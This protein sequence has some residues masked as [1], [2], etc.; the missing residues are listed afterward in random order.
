MARYPPWGHNGGPN[1]EGRRTNPDLWR[2]IIRMADKRVS[3]ASRSPATLV[4][5][6][7]SLKK[8]LDVGWSVH[9]I[10]QTA[11]VH[12]HILKW[13][14]SGP[15]DIPHQCPATSCLARPTLQTGGFSPGGPDQNNP[16]DRAN[17]AEVGGFR[18]QERDKASPRHTAGQMVGT[19]AARGCHCELARIGFRVGNQLWKAVCRAPFHRRCPHVRIP[20][21][22]LPSPT[23]ADEYSENVPISMQV[24]A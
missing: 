6:L 21:R 13:A 18:C 7:P 4:L 9:S 15:C 1:G 24:V 16:P 11:S 17:W 5:A 22:P 10:L 19:S 14:A 23:L 3:A 12:A 20:V 2:G 8:H